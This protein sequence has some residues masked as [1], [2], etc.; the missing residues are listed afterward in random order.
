MVMIGVWP[1]VVWLFML[2]NLAVGGRQRAAISGGAFR[3][4]THI[5]IEKKLF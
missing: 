1:H 2:F 3:K 5:E 4:Q